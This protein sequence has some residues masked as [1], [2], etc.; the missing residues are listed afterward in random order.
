MNWFA[1]EFFFCSLFATIATFGFAGDSVGGKKI[2]LPVPI[3]HQVKGLRVPIRNEEG[4]M[5]MQFDMESARRIN[6]QDIEMHAAVIQ[7]Y[8][9][10][11]A[12]PD[13]KIELRTA[14]MNLD[15]NVIKTSEP[16]RI[17]REDFVLTADGGEFN[18]KLRQ[19]RVLGNI[20]LIVYNRDKFQTKPGGGGSTSINQ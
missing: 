18:S 10:Q 2:D 6:D 14:L 8:D 7:T 15:T 4:K 12:K 11:N 1:K 3:G 13:A 19:G 17:S 20:H 9:Q 16:V 5:E